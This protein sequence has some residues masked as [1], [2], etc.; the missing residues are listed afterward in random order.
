[1]GTFGKLGVRRRLGR[2]WFAGLLALLI[3][4]NPVT[5]ATAGS[6][7]AGD[8]YFPLQGNGGY[9]VTHYGLDLHWDPATDRLDGV[10]TIAA[11]ATQSLSAFDLD[12]RRQLAVSSVRVDGDA[13]RFE[14][15]APLGQELIVKPRHAI[16]DGRSF[17]VVVTYGG[18]P[19][20]VIDPDGGMEGW[21]PTDDGAFVVGE[22]Q[23]SPSWFP[24]NDTPTDKATFDIR[25]TVPKGLTAVSNGELVG[26]PTT[27]HGWTTFA[28][29][30]RHPMS[31]YLATATVGR[32]VTATGMTQGGVPWYTAVDKKLDGKSSHD[33]LKTLPTIVDY[34]ASR[35][36]P[37][38]FDSIG[39]IIDDASSV[40]YA[41]ETTTKPLFP[42]VPDDVWL[43]H[44]L[45]H[46]WFG[47]SVTLAR[48]RDI[49]VNEG[50]AEW[51][52]WLWSEASGQDSA[53]AIFD[54]WYSQPASE[55]WI[56]DPSPAD[57]GG[58]DN[59]FASS[60]YVRGAMTLQ[61]L[62]VKVG[63]PTFFKIMKGWAAQRKYGN[64]TVDEFT[65]Y[66]AHEAHRNL[67][68]FFDVWLYQP[69]KPA[70]W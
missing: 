15:P 37:Y 57:P 11:V 48:W 27:D 65:A 45:A 46:Q 13:A 55:D 68:S 38:P 28:W 1:M 32:F 20:V 8:P 44:E 4:A 23:G 22:P 9:Q 49:W 64:G 2:A 18:V 14:Q 17:T 61:A 51:S 6:S 59:Q 69:G 41:L 56:W 33:V 34:F 12:L 29:R 70:S 7:G 19:P 40:G 63:D 62:R 47:D 43:A 60:I 36:G 30:E 25:V 50:F 54:Y 10:A 42:E 52:S 24:C 66:A 67:T 53:Q 5:A 26:P 35:F 39:A 58:P 16:G 3:A 21:I 31:T